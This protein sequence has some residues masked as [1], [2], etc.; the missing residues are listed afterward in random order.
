ME[1]QRCACSDAA[2]EV[3]LNCGSATPSLTADCY[4]YADAEHGQYTNPCS[5]KQN[6]HARIVQRLWEG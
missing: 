2:Q 4:N 6:L 5:A 3:A 1:E